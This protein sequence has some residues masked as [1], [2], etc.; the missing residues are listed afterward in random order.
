MNYY[1]IIKRNEQGDE[2]GLQAL[3][4]TICS[5]T[6]LGRRRKGRQK[7]DQTQDVTH[8]GIRLPDDD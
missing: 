8:Q 5:L 4:A 2:G 6:H 1:F 7:D 3:K